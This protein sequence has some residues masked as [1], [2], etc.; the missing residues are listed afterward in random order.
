M[1]FPQ[2]WRNRREACGLLAS[3]NRCPAQPQAL[4]AK[5][6]LFAILRACACNGETLRLYMCTVVK[7]FTFTTISV[8]SFSIS[9]GG[10]IPRAL[11]FFPLTVWSSFSMV[12]LHYTRSFIQVS[13]PWEGRRD[14]ARG[15]GMSAGVSSGYRLPGGER[16]VASGSISVRGLPWVWGNRFFCRGIVIIVTIWGG[17]ESRKIPVSIYVSFNS[18]RRS[19][20]QVLPLE[21]FPLKFVLLSPI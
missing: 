12:M 16:V 14:A 21:Y 17:S 18:G 15:A 5:V 20:E 6:L 2:Q 11:H 3:R 7:V 8:S 1:D 4:F 13:R 9:V 10:K 19:E